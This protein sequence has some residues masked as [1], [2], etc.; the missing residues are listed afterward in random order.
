[1]TTL[2]ENGFG[3][4]HNP[5]SG[6]PTGLRRGSAFNAAVASYRLS[7]VLMFDRLIAGAVPHRDQP[8]VRHDGL[9]HFKPQVLRSGHM[10]ADTPVEEQIL[11]PGD[12]VVFDTLRPQRT[13]VVS[14]LRHPQSPPLRHR[15]GVAGV[16]HLHGAVL[17]LTAAGLLGGEALAVLAF[18]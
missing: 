3:A 7:P 15:G 13:V 4:D 2:D 5:H 12:V 9:D 10:M 1:M 17:S 18:A 6:C 11:E 14:R 16:R 8:R